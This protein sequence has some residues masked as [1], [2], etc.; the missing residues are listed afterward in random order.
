MNES[1]PT[2]PRALAA[3]AVTVLAWSGVP[4]LLKH[5]T[6]VGLDA[7]T[8]N[9]CR[10]VFTVMLW[11]PF[12]IRHYRDIPPDRNVWR[13]A[14]WPAFFHLAGQV[15][16]GLAP[17]YNDASVMNFVSRLGFLCTI[18]FGFW[19]LRD[20]RT[21]A[22]RPLFWIGVAGSI[23]GL[24]AMFGGGLNV[25]NTSVIGMALLVWT[26]VCWGLYAV[27]VKRTMQAYPA[28]LG[29]GIVSVLVAPG[30]VVLMFLFGDWRAALH[31]NLLYWSLLAGSA[32]IGIA[33]GHVLYYQAVKALGPVVA[34]GALALIPFV[35]A[36]AAHAILGERMMLMQWIGGTVMVLATLCLLWAKKLE[37]AMVIPE[38]PGG[39]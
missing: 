31:L 39:G 36:I 6:H 5:F 33:M 26:S 10:Y 7:W 12:V 27:N 24:L 13:D 35:T 15:G 30:L 9:G 16:W 4:L 18:V 17:Y 34:E 19:L 29:F 14:A 2:V 37:T 8:V 23:A 32:W 25:G 3:L 38:E 20:E 1:Q 28:R 21:L 11:L 22:R